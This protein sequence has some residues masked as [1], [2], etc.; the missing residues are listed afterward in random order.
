M[1]ALIAKSLILELRAQW[2][3]RALLI[4]HQQ[5]PPNSAMSSHHWMEDY[6]LT[7]GSGM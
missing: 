6:T 5:S 1:D 4:V 3:S 7:L 2:R